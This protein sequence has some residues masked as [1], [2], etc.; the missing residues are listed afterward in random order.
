M[1]Y[2]PAEHRAEL[3]PLI[4]AL[5]ARI[6]ERAE[7]SDGEL[8]AAGLLNYACTRLVLRLVKLR[9]GRVRYGV[10][11]LVTG[12][13]HNVADELYRRVGHPY[14][15][16]QIARSGDVDLYAEFAAEIERL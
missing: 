16:K 12:V 10:V 1:P 14:E 9:F 6:A 13:L 15:D 2:I 8:A 11:A 3:D 4:D 7:R 5:S